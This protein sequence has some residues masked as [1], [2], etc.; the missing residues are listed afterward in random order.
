MIY[1][2][3]CLVIYAIEPNG[4]A[5]EAVITALAQTHDAVA[6][7]PLVMMECMVGPIRA[8]DQGLRRTYEEFFEVLEIIP[9]TAEIFRLAAEL[10]GRTGLRTPDAIHLAAARHAGCTALW[11]NDH[12]LAAVAGELAV[13]I[14]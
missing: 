11:T 10:R 3:S 8:G 13:I 1:L 6:V 4:A 5:S 2:D 7:S 12:R 14:A 9:L